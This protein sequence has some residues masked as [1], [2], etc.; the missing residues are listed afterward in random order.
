MAAIASEMTVDEKKFDHSPDEQPAA[1]GE[2][3]T[4]EDAEKEKMLRA[5]K[6][7]T[8]DRIAYPTALL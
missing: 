2:S 7:S 5:V 1:V 3:S 6:Q 4:S 8:S